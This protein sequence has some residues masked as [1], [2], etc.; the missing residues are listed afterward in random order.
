MKVFLTAALCALILAGCGVNPPVSGPAAK[1]GPPAATAKSGGYYL[2]DGPPAHPPADLDAV[3][4]AV[5]RAEPLHRFANRTYVALG[6]TYTPQTERRAHSEEGLASWYG[7][8]FHGKKTASGELYDM[9]AMTA[10][11]PTLPIPSYARVTAL[12]SGKSVVVRINDRGPFHS[13]R[14]IDLSYTAAHKLGYVGAGS[15]RVR[16]ESLDPAAYDTQGE[17]LAGG[18]YLQLGA[19]SREKNARALRDRVR[20][21]LELTDEQTRLVLTGALHRVQIGPYPDDE[22]ARI[23]RA[24]V[25]EHLDLNAVLV[26]RD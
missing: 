18:L 12:G 7:R 5:P 16:V 13:K 22:A 3:P 2:D 26:R 23:D 14:I 10:A 17:A 21:A 24:R 20:N 4:D 9:Y 11:H 25:R 1:A 15:A 19:F 6:N 8:R